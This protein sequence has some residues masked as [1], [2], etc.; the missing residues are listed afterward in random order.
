MRKKLAW[1][2][3]E[4][5]LEAGI[6]NTVVYEN[7]PSKYAQFYNG[8]TYNFNYVYY[9]ESSKKFL[10]ATKTGSSGSSVKAMTN[11]QVESAISAAE[12]YAASLGKTFKVDGIRFAIN[13]DEAYTRFPNKVSSKTVDKIEMSFIL[14]F[15]GFAGTKE[16][17]LEDSP[18]DDILAKYRIERQDLYGK[19][20]RGT[21]ERGS[22][23]IYTY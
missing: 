20:I 4:G 8:N 3:I 12:K 22:K 5:K 2:K 19:S 11:E 21:E 1:S 17:L 6:V 16:S 23:M 9:G 7:A 18:M 15:G 14:D 13:A 10:I